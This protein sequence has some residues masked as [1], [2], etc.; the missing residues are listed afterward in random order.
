MGYSDMKIHPRGILNFDL[1]P[2]EARIKFGEMVL[3]R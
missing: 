3:Y 2:L 1:S